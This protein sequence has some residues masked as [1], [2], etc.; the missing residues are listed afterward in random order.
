M[1]RKLGE[2]APGDERGPA[3]IPE[4]ARVRTAGRGA[5]P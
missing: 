3:P 2:R 5:L 4:R 1:P